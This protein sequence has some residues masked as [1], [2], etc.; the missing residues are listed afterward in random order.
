MNHLDSIRENI[1]GP[2]FS[3]M[4]PFRVEDD[5]IDFPVLGKYLERIY[6][7]GGRIFYVMGYNSRFSELSWEEIKVLN[8]FVTR[9]VKSMGSDTMIISS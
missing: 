6:E 1:K 8:T 2:L 4:T 3:V 7:A 9:V 5:S